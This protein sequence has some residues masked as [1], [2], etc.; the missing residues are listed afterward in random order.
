VSWHYKIYLNFSDVLYAYTSSCDR[1]VAS[2]RVLLLLLLLDL[3]K[4]VIH[5]RTRDT[6]LFCTVFLTVFISHLARPNERFADCYFIAHA[7]VNTGKPIMLCPVTIIAG[8]LQMVSEWWWSLVLMLSAA[9]GHVPCQHSYG[10][11]RYNEQPFVPAPVGQV[12][13]CVQNYHGEVTY[14]ETID[15]YPEWVL[16]LFLLFLSSLS[17]SLS[18]TLPREY[19]KNIERKYV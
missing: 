6:N 10:G 11:C 3:F 18:L 19:Y 15:R 13:G 12:P 14:C 2:A 16:F 8:C 7:V 1:P 5:N 4:S 9:Y 17:L